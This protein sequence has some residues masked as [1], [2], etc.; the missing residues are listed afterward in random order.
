MTEIIENG[1]FDLRVFVVQLDVAFYL[2]N[3]D[4]I[5]YLKVTF[6][7]IPTGIVDHTIETMTIRIN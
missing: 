3:K 2:G 4:L 7:L 1:F 5:S 6:N